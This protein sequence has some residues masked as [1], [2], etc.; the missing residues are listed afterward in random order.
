MMDQHVKKKMDVLFVLHK[1]DL[2]Y[3]KYFFVGEF[4]IDLNTY[5]KKI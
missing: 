3:D 1:F 5:L 2:N 4:K